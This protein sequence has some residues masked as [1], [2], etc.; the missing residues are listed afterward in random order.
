MKRLLFV[1]SEDWYF[2]SHRLHLALRALDAG[3]R[4][5][6]LCRLSV[7]RRRLEEAG[8]E[9]FEWSL[10][11]RSGALLREW[12]AVR[13]LRDALR[14]FKPSIVHAVALKPVLYSALASIAQQPCGKVYAL[15]GLGFVFAST[16]LLARVLRPLV[17]QALRLSFSGPSTRL[18]VQNPDDR[19][20]LLNARSIEAGKVRLI[21]GA[22]VDTGAFAPTPE[23]GGEALVMLP[24]RLLWDK[25]VG[26]FVEAARILRRRGT[27]ARFALVGDRD[28]HNPACVALEQLASWRAE[29]VV[30]CW[31]RRD[32]MPAA[33]AQADVV[34]LPSRREGL[35][36]AL[37]EAASCAKPIVAFDVPG[38]REVVVHGGNG[39]LA[40][41]GDV[42]ALADA[43][44][45]LLM[46][47]PLRRRM[48]TQ[49]RLLVEQQFSQELVADQT[50]QVWREVTA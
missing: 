14:S 34:C 9:V 17:M 2:V 35:P 5:A 26:E 39:L 27:R 21:R 6:V 28:E 29:G 24:A 46:D 23:H 12:R 20:L 37:L 44:E 10:E 30:E 8:I 18:I 4:V 1:V 15:G 41:A 40:P 16:R 31:G 33:L 45:T 3:Y 50:M 13:E 38:C 43:L 36:K 42:P 48:G 22:G 49:G 32:D 25:G 7:H 19:A 47:V 11:R